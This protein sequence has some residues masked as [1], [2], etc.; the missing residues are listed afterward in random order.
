MARQMGALVLDE[1][2]EAEDLVDHAI[3]FI[4]DSVSIRPDRPFLLYLAFGATHAPHQAPAD[5]MAKYRGRF[6]GMLVGLAKKATKTKAGVAVVANEYVLF[7][8]GENPKFVTIW[9]HANKCLTSV[10]AST[11]AE[12]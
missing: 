7:E 5:Y 8:R 4:H 2:L 3:E 9:S 10:R 6:D 1:A 11:I 12:V